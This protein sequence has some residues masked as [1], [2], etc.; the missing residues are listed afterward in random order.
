MRATNHASKFCRKSLTGMENPKFS[1][2]GLTRAL[3]TIWIGHQVMLVSEVLPSGK[4][5][6]QESP[7]LLVASLMTFLE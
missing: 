7:N 6:P 5:S 2:L 4:R 3:Q 1:S